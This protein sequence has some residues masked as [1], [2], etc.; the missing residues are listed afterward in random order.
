MAV[1][2]LSNNAWQV[3]A[4]GQ[5]RYSLPLGPATYQVGSTVQTFQTGSRN[6]LEFG[7]FPPTQ[8]G[9]VNSGF[10]IPIYLVQVYV[11]SNGLLQSRFVDQSTK[12]S[13]PASS[14]AI[15]LCRVDAVGR[16]HE[17]DDYRGSDGIIQGAI[18]LKGSRTI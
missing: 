17:V 13:F 5:C 10:Q 15:A 8:A 14:V 16:I 4:D 12:A 18:S 7:I 1:T 6:V 9:T 3:P 2:V 11:D